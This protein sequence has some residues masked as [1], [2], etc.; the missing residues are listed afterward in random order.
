MSVL[1]VKNNGVW[2]NVGYPSISDANT[3]GGKTA[4]EFALTS[5]IEEL[6]LQV[7]DKSVAD[8]ISDALVNQEFEQAAFKWHRVGGKCTNYTDLD[9]MLQNLEALTYQSTIINITIASGGELHT[10]LTSKNGKDTYGEFLGIPYMYENITGV[11]VYG[12]KLI[13][14]EDNSLWDYLPENSGGPRSLTKLSEN[15]VPVERTIAG[16]DLVD[17]I[18][19]D[20]LRASLSVYPVMKLTTQPTEQ[21]VGNKGQFAYF[22]SYDGKTYVYTFYYCLDVNDNRYFWTQVGGSASGSDVREISATEIN[23]SGELI[24]IYSDNTSDN[25]GVVVGQDG[26]DGTDGY[27]PVKGVDYFT[28]ADKAEIVNET[29]NSIS[30]NEYV[31]SVNN[32]L[33]DANGNVTLTI[34]AEQP[35]F[36]VKD[37]LEEALEWLNENGNTSKTYVLPDGY[38]YKYTTS[39]ITYDKPNCNNL[40]KLENSQVGY[41]ISSAGLLKVL[42]GRTITNAIPVNAGETYDIRFY[43]TGGSGISQIVEFSD[44]PTF[45]VDAQPT[46][47]ISHTANLTKTWDEPN[48]LT[49]KF[50]HTMSSTTKYFALDVFLSDTTKLATAVIT[51]NEAV[52]LGTTPVTEETTEWINTGHSYQATD[53]EDRII[54]IEE[55]NT[56]QEIRLAALEGGTVSAIPSYWQSHLD[57]KVDDIREAMELAGRNKSAFLFYSDA[58]WDD[59]GKQSPMLLNYLFKHT[60][61]NKTLFG[62]DIVNVEPTTETLSDRTIMEYL[63]DWR[64]QIRDLKHYS[65][66]GN[67]DDGNATNNI[68]SSDYVYSFLFAP[69]EDNRGIVRDAD[70]Y[71]YFDDTREKTRYIC[72]DTAYESAYTLSAAQETFI[73][74]TLK[75]TPENYH[76]IIL[77]HIWY[78]PDYDQ[79]SVRPIPLTGLSTTAQS[80]CNILDAYNARNGEFADCK[81]KIEFCIGGHVHRDY[82]NKTTGGIPIVLCDCAGLGYRGSFTASTGNISETTVSGIVADYDNDKLSVIRVGRGN[83]FE[84]ALSTGAATEI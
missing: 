3:L 61:I 83:S 54:A 49:S 76:I 70:T 17:D 40:F 27:T 7:G 4:D 19:E 6:Q 15:S 74:E 56:N 73:K 77:S 10:D 50:T 67:H 60:P 39:T 24:V 37:T 32:T 44:I 43:D 71:Y 68:F 75:S 52:D 84:V 5:D 81:A 58:H 41:R 18:T 42:D 33:P 28:S 78:M 31:K 30:L 51:L 1:K 22:V 38:L 45:T 63:W 53:Y 8:Q 36:V 20:E 11:R 82:V 25:L 66:I 35:E 26:K 64:S 14:L 13:C 80:V 9:S 65:V 16:L 23:A 62:G 72:L 46:N 79:Y 55:V 21:T 69:E 48:N 29:K 47:Y 12:V 34:T 59:G 57:E 2:K